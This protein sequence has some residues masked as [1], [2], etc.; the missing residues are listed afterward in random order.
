MGVKPCESV[1]LMSFSWVIKKAVLTWFDH[2]NGLHHEKGMY[3]VCCNWNI[4]FVTHE[5]LKGHTVHID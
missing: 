1:S 4:D 5:L 2:Y 3:D